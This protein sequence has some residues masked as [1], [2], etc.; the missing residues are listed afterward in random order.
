MAAG[1]DL[2]YA[3]KHDAVHN[4]PINFQLRT[5]FYL[6]PSI[7]SSIT[8]M[9]LSGQE[10]K[11]SPAESYSRWSIWYDIAIIFITLGKVAFVACIR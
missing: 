7:K 3:N 11:S 2:A 1:A 10:I 8:N 5:D 9:L 6:L 4:V